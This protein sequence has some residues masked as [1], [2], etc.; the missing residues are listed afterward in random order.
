MLKKVLLYLDAPLLGKVLIP[1]VPEL[2][3]LFYNPENMDEETKQKVLESALAKVHPGVL[4]Q[5]SLM[6]KRG[7]FVSADGEYSYLKNL[8]KVRIPLLIIGGEKDSLAPAQTLRT[9]YRRARSKVRT[10]K[11]YG[12]SSKDSAKYGHFD[13][14]VGK[15]AKGEVFPRIA[16]WLKRRHGR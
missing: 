8:W 2:E 11:I 15:K 7:E 12:S 10:L 5:L 4:D 9:V 14:I 6:I 16:K 13:L 1:I 3:K